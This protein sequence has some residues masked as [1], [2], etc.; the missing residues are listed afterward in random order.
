MVLSQFNLGYMDMEQSILHR[1]DAGEIGVAEALKIAR[2]G[3]E[4][5]GGA[6]SVGFIDALVE[7][8][9]ADTAEET[10]AVVVEEAPAE[11]EIKIDP[12]VE[13]MTEASPEVV[14][15]VPVDMTAPEAIEEMAVVPEN[16]EVAEVKEE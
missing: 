1:V 16:V 5:F 15:E 4:E 9:L 13:A 12:V 8:G 7:R 10:P 6:P 11:M 14:D 2:E 3:A